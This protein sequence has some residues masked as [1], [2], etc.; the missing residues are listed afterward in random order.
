M[1]NITTIQTYLHTCGGKLSSCAVIAL[2]KRNFS[3]L[4]L[5]W[6]SS[7]NSSVS[8]RSFLKK[9]SGLRQRVITS[10]GFGRLAGLAP[11]SS[12]Y[13]GVTDLG[14]CSVQMGQRHYQFKLSRN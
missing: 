1:T 2:K 8:T 12:Q 13:S 6:I 10:A 9:P 3:A 4:S 11:T 5:I 7:R 14:I